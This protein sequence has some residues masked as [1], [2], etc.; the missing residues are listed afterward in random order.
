[1]SQPELLKTVVAILNAAK[2][3]YMVTGSVVSSL[4]GEP[5]STHDIDLVVDLSAAQADTV[6]AAFAGPEYYLAES[7]VRDAI[8]CRSMFNLLA[9]SEGD[10]VDFWM[11]TLEE[12]DRSRFER[13]QAI[14]FE[15]IQLFV[16]APED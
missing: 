5:R 11:L 13:R 8:E 9:V 16:S 3:Q 1:M 2:V 6:I 15:G 10:K 14:D 7:S 12:F 4:Q